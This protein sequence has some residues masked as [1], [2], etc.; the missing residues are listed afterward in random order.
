MSLKD[1]LTYEHFA[2]VALELFTAYI[3][4]QIGRCVSFLVPNRFVG[5]PNEKESDWPCGF[6]LIYRAHSQ[7]KRRKS[8]LILQIQIWLPSKQIAQ[9]NLTLRV[10]CPM[11][12]RASPLVLL[13]DIYVEAFEKEQR[14]RLVSLRRHM[15]HVQHKKVLSILVSS[16]TNQRVNCIKIASERRQVKWRELVLLRSGVRPLSNLIGRGSL[17][18]F[19]H[20]DYK[21]DLA[22]HTFEHRVMQDG[23]AL[24]IGKFCQIGRRAL[25]VCLK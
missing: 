4:N 2:K 8:F 13:I 18:L 3:L 20:L 15:K 1:Q 12:W 25:K 21:L 14:R 7:V 16:M 23:E 17:Q 24:F 9:R 22:R 5:S 10:A 6:N 19:S 11:Q